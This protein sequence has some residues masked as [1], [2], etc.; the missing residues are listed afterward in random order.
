MLRRAIHDVWQRESRFPAS[1]MFALRPA[2][3]HMHLHLFKVGGGVTFVTPIHPHPLPAEHAVTAIRGVLEF[4]HAHPGCTRQQLLDG[5]QPGAATE[6]PEVVAV[7]NPLRWLID[8]GHVIEFFNG[9]LAVPMSG[10]RAD[11]PQTAQ[12]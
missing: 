12:A 1:L 3:K 11:R 6:S 8:R 7:L 5:L 2:F 10:T 4:L 9:T